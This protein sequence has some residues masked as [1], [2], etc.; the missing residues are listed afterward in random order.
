MQR[1]K[2]LNNV[3]LSDANSEDSRPV[4]PLASAGGSMDG[5]AWHN[6]S[7]DLQPMR[8]AAMPRMVSRLHAQWLSKA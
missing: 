6:W 7:Q 2:I 5:D 1:D 3:V 8:L 4:V